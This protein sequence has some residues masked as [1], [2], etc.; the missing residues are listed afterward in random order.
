MSGDNAISYG[1]FDGFTWIR[2][3]GKGSFLVSP[4]VKECAR[5]RQEQGERR[6]VIDLEECTGMDSTFMGT[7]AGLARSVGSDQGCVQIASP[8]DRNRQS[9]EDLGLDF[10]ID[11]APESAAWLSKEDDIRA[12]L[13]PF[14]EKRHASQ[15]ERA[16]HVLESHRNLCETSDENKE[17]FANVLEV[18]EKQVSPERDKTG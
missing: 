7:L 17:R 18:F 12:D 13:E 15:D 3:E 10:F 16:R 2:C 11:I 4:A 1:V 5:Q 14:V 8:G 6:F 9:L